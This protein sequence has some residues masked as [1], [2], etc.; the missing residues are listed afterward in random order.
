M[1]NALDE[2]FNL[3]M[4]DANQLGSTSQRL[5]LD[6]NINNNEDIPDNES[7]FNSTKSKSSISFKNI[8]YWICIILLV[9]VICVIVYYIL[10]KLFLIVPKEEIKEKDKKKEEKDKK[11]KKDKKITKMSKTKS[12]KCVNL[13][14]IKSIVSDLSDISEISSV[15]S[16]N[17][18]SDSSQEMSTKDKLDLYLNQI[19]KS[20]S[21]KIKEIEEN[22]DKTTTRTTSHTTSNAK[23]HNNLNKELMMELYNESK[24]NENVEKEDAKKRRGRPRKNV[25]D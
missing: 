25:N 7:I 2:H 3:L 20:E 6:N 21:S 15:S 4:S 13:K 17:S 14:K 11:N 1:D 5:V 8:V 19:A 10:C 24:N 16:I 23:V 12:K 9:I 22:S 18:D